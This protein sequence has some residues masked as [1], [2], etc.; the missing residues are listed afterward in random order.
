MQR[1]QYIGISSIIFTIKLN[2]ESVLSKDSVNKAL[3]NPGISK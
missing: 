3:T 1:C 2:I